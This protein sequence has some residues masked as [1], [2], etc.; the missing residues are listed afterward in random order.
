ME[1]LMKVILMADLKGLDLSVG[2]KGKEV[3]LADLKGLKIMEMIIMNNMN[4]KVL[5]KVILRFCALTKKVYL[6]SKLQIFL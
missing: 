5:M 4:M 6:S 2:L 3:L 1:V